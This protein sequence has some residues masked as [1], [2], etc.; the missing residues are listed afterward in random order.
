MKDFW[1]SQIELAE[2]FSEGDIRTKIIVPLLHYLGYK[3]ENWRQEYNTDK[4]LLDFVIG[5]T[6]DNQF[7]PFFLLEVKSPKS[8]LALYAH[9]MEY[10]LFSMPFLLQS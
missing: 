9:Q 10:W 5:Q 4:G 2:C 1:Q 6:Q 7:Q 8:T 3:P